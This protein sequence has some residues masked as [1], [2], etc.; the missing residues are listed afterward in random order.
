MIS[1]K[2]KIRL[3]GICKELVSLPKSNH[4]HFSFLLN[5]KKIV[6]VGWNNGWKSH[7]IANK[8]GHR[9][10]SIHSELACI[11][12]CNTDITKLVLVNIRIMADNTLGRAFPCENCIDMLKDF[13]FNKV[14]CSDYKN[15]FHSFYL[16]G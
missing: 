6:S 1:D 12:N 15:R 7:P 4:K 9:F 3:V 8:Y 14:I 11:I 2:V 16:T 10:D 13:G 5:K